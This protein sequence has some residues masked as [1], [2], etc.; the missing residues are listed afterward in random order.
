[1]LLW[2]SQTSDASTSCAV[3]IIAMYGVWVSPAFFSERLRQPI[4]F[5]LRSVLFQM[6]EEFCF[7]HHILCVSSLTLLLFPPLSVPRCLA[8][9]YLSDSL[10]SSPAPSS[11]SC[12]PCSGESL[13]LHLHNSTAVLTI[14]DYLVTT[15]TSTPMGNTQHKHISG[16]VFSPIYSTPQRQYHHGKAKCMCH[17][18]QCYTCQ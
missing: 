12:R 10:H 6:H 15:R 1:M 8:L 17:S 13:I 2:R 3:I 7:S 18:D 9:D 4:L 16:R 11:H 14:T 5:N